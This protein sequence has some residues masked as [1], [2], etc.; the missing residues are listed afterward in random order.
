MKKIFF[1]FLL[2]FAGFLVSQA[3]G[4]NVNLE[5]DIQTL[6]A[7]F[8]S[9]TSVEVSGYLILDQGT[10]EQ[11]Y[12]SK[13]KQI[14]F[15]VGTNQSNVE[16]SSCGIITNQS[17]WLIPGT[18]AYGGYIMHGQTS[19]F[20]KQFTG[21]QPGTTYYY[22]ACGIL[23]S[24]INVDGEIVSFAMPTTQQL[25]NIE[26]ETLAVQQN[27]IT[28]QSAT[29]RRKIVTP[30]I[31]ES[32]Y[33]INT[34]QNGNNVAGECVYDR[35]EQHY[36]DSFRNS[37]IEDL[38]PSTNYFYQACAKSLGGGTEVRG[39]I[40]SFTTSQVPDNTVIEGCSVNSLSIDTINT[41]GNVVDSNT[42]IEISVSGCND[43]VVIKAAGLENLTPRFVRI[44]EMPPLIKPT[45]SGQ[46]VVEV[47]SDE[48]ECHEENRDG[49]GGSTKWGWDCVY[50]FQ[51]YDA[52]NDELI[53]NSSSTWGE[54]PELSA[55]LIF[56]QGAE[57]IED[58]EEIMAER[59]VGLA[60]CAGS[61][62][63]GN[64]LGWDSDN[65]DFE[66]IIL[67]IDGTNTVCNLESS[68]ISFNQHN[69]II[70][71]AL[72]VLKVNT[73]NCVNSPISIEFPDNNTSGGVTFDIG[74]ET[75][76][77]LEVTPNGELLTMTFRAHND[78]CNTDYDPDCNFSVEIE[79][80]AGDTVNTINNT[81]SGE[82]HERGLVLA[83]CAEGLCGGTNWTIESVSGID[84]NSGLPESVFP[85]SSI[86]PSG[87]CA[88][89][90]LTGYKDNCYEFLSPIP[91]LGNITDPNDPR[92]VA[93]D[94]TTFKF[95]DYVNSLFQ[96]ALGLLMVL[97]VIMIVVAGVQY[98][99]EESLTGKSNARTRITQALMGLV[100][101]L[102]IY[103]ILNTINPQLLQVNFG[104]NIEEV[105]VN[106]EDEA[107][108]KE[109]I[110]NDS[111]YPPYP[112][113][114]GDGS[115]T[116]PK[117]PQ[118]ITQ[119]GSTYLCSSIS[120]EYQNLLTN[121]ATDS[122]SLGGGGFRTM[123]QQAYLRIKNGCPDIHNA[124]SSSCTI[125]TA[126][127][128]KSEHNSGLAIDFTC[129]V[130]GQTGTIN[131]H[132]GNTNGTKKEW[133]R[134]CYNWM[135]DNANSYGLFNLKRG[136]RSIENWHWS[137]TG[138]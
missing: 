94:V 84:P 4:G 39:E 71:D 97:S 12:N 89:E 100:L 68:D 34:N 113:N 70:D 118:G 10:L 91:G 5:Y 20:K 65:W 27:N 36:P 43:G 51:I 55:S 40:V 74:G 88:N 67:G 123:E 15:A 46:I 29:L 108:I 112:P 2:F 13:M 90:D 127:P 129:T 22:K 26:V 24:G 110:A 99:T 75:T 11:K 111:Q 62:G 120:E 56:D 116:T 63:E 1:T 49:E 138:R 32:G 57:M 7:E 86:I 45:N 96:V 82:P 78:D 19:P 130:G 48:A 101:G 134:D 25:E 64:L 105:R 52:S 47:E 21:L 41:L 102:S 42:D 109:V 124:P 59:G 72:I 135:V 121:A 107:A 50:Y 128:G 77:T 28:Y 23:D 16:L 115:Y 87:P 92:R 76:D 66:E 30:Y 125:P 60:N 85:G 119:V 58:I 17:S 132:D 83:N 61:C 6:P 81:G 9:Q 73:T 8:L 103:I 98:M 31:R 114:L 3:Q 54:H 79:N 18:G 117:C 131:V 35:N 104:S 80:V 14:G 93:V 38:L 137:T 136:G 133:T 106:Q 53:F 44:E 69:E 122:I 33:I 126:P 37:N 95:E